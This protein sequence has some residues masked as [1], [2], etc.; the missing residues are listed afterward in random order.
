MRSEKNVMAGL[1]IMRNRLF[2]PSN[3]NKKWSMKLGQGKLQDIELVS[4][5]GIIL[6]NEVFLVFIM[7]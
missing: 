2:S 5:M 7:D 6:I 1:S 3:I 4:Q